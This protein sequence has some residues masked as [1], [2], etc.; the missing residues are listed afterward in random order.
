MGLLGL[1]VMAILMMY[2][3][4]GAIILSIIFIAITSWPRNNAV[5]YFPYTPQGDTMF[6]YFK[7]VVS[8]HKMTQ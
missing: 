1:V 5:T 7:Q 2:R 8:V 4:R 6:D 3:V